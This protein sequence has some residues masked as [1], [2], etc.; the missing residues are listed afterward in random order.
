MSIWDLNI[1]N[2][3]GCYVLG[4]EILNWQNLYKYSKIWGKHPQTNKLWT[5]NPSSP[6]D[7]TCRVHWTCVLTKILPLGSASGAHN[8]RHFI[9]KAFFLPNGKQLADRPMQKVPELSRCEQ[10]WPDNWVCTGVHQEAE[11][12]GRIPATHS[13]ENEGE[14][15]WRANSRH[16]Q[17]ILHKEPSS[18][19][20]WRADVLRIS[21]NNSKH[22]R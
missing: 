14:R 3:R 9:F 1:S 18:T 6:T 16:M 20:L 8:L 19:S 13:T 12:M 11:P 2:F 7:F 15:P 10:R 4:L 5:Q 21:V 22:R 17:I